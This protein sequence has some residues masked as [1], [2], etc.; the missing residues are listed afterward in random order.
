MKPLKKFLLAGITCSLITASCHTEQKNLPNKEAA[1]GQS[2]LWRIEGNGLKKVSWLFGTMHLMP[3]SKFV[4]NQQLQH[5]L[6]A[7]DSV[8]FEINL[9]DKKANLEAIPKMILPD[10][11]LLSHYYTAGQ[12]DTIRSFILDTLGK[13][14]VEW[15]YFQNLKPIFISETFYETSFGDSTESYELT[16]QKL[17]NENHIPVSGLETA[18]YQAS[19]LDSIPLDIQA[20]MLINEIRNYRKDLTKLNHLIELYSTQQIDSMDENIE[21]DKELSEY[22]GILLHNRNKNW[23]KPIESLV[24]NAS[25]FIAVGAGHLPGEKGLIQLLR[26]DGYTLTPI[27]FISNEEE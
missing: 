23:I 27:D 2:M 10:G 21:E 18:V 8:V 25:C 5:V 16:F 13:S 19:L 15:A 12:F 22:T 14:K 7:A 17:A 4:F 26:N 1:N 3:K 6:L 20:K 9:N 11:F 24:A